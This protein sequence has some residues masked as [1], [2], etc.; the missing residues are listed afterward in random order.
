MVV[1]LS[2]DGGV[3]PGGTCRNPSPKRRELPCLE[4]KPHGQAG[5]LELALEVGTQRAGLDSRRLRRGVDLKHAIEPLQVD[6][7]RA[8]IA[9]VA[10]RVHAADHAGATA[11]RDRRDIVRAAPV[12]HRADVRFVTRVSDDIGRVGEIAPVNHPRE[13]V[14]RA[15]VTMKQPVV[16]IFGTESLQTGR[17]RQPGLAQGDL[18]LARQGGRIEAVDMKELRPGALEPADLV[19][20]NHVVLVSPAEETASS[21]AH[22]HFSSQ[23]ISLCGRMCLTAPAQCPANVA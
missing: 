10:G 7:Q 8:A 13:I 14:N 6:G 19:G 16:F 23:P 4:K 17:H 12:Q 15:A 2:V 3:V 5:R 1:D 9:L 22:E 11:E 21:F 18:G 20:R